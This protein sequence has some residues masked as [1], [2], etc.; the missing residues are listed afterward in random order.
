MPGMAQALT[1]AGAGL[2]AF[3]LLFSQGIGDVSASLFWG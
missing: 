3:T 1:F 2:E